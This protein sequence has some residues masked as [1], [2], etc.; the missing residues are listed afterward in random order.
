MT[1][2][3]YPYPSTSDDTQSQLA[4]PNAFVQSLI[5]LLLVGTHF[6]RS[7]LLEQM[8]R[9][10]LRDPRRCAGDVVSRGARNEKG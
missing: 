4:D 6:L 10:L 2:R 5:L 9:R 8:I 7:I 3:T 1:L